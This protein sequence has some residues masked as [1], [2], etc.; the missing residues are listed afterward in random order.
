MYGPLLFIVLLI[1]IVGIVSFC[2]NRSIK[3]EELITEEHDKIYEEKTYLINKIRHNIDYYRIDAECLSLIDKYYSLYVANDYDKH[4]LFLCLS[5]IAK[6]RLERFT[7]NINNSLCCI[8]KCFPNIY[9]EFD[10]VKID[11]K[12]H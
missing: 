6:F 5:E 11:P 10:D 8:I 3:K 1:F 2:I 4:C 7:K 9:N 12:E